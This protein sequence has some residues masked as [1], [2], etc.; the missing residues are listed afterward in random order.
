[1]IEVRPPQVRRRLGWALLAVLVAWLVATTVN[2]LITGNFWLGPIPNP[3]PP[4]LFFAGPPLL[5]FGLA[6]L[7]LRR[8][9]L[10]R[11]D[12]R[13]LAAAIAAALL[14][15]LHLLLS[16]RTWLWVLPDLMP[17]VLFL[18]LPLGVLAALAA[19]RPRR[20][21]SVT[22]AVLSVVALGLGFGQAG[23]NLPGG[24]NDGPA[25]L[26]ALRVVTWDTLDWTTDKDPDRFYDFLTKRNADVYLLQNYA[27][28]GPE[29]F[30]LG[31]DEDRLR[32]T[33]PG[34]EFATVGTLLTIS[35]FPIVAQVPIETNPTPPPGTANIWYLSAWK[36]G[37]LRTDLDV[38][39][40]IL[41]VYNVFFY[42]RFFLHVMPLTPAFFTNIRGL[43]EGR[44]A[45]LDQ[46]LAETRSN[47]NPFVIS[48]NLNVLPNTGDRH[49]L[50]VYKDAGRAD[51]SPYPASLTFVGLS[52]WRMDWTFTSPTIGVHSYDL[53][54][55]DGL[56][57][58]HLQ[59][60]VL[61]LR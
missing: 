32:R 16:G 4:L 55:P 17:P 21:V 24:V 2:Q 43:N 54:P 20:A 48:G 25:P 38:R 18:L 35:R 12:R 8:T 9:A 47:P 39:G 10:S 41:S 36:Y 1:M 22:V 44:D 7:A 45:Q 6:T 30:R 52:L 37:M 46:L 61:S 19:I 33:F 27:H 29:T 56:S 40:R 5:L 34:Y 53:V 23:L 26:G 11:V 59:D 49:R 3:L 13:L 51:G 15:V 14:T 58:R 31:A 57:S 28:T 50:D 42:D 60:V